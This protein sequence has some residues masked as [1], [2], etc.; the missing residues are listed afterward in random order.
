MIRVSPDTHAVLRELARSEGSSMQEVLSKAV[1]VYRRQQLI[2]ATHAAYAALRA[3]T[4][5]WQE[6]QDEVASLDG[7]LM[8]GLEPEGAPPK[9]AAAPVGR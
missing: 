8:D 4:Q 3:D 7:A 5:A 9:R 1:E 2:E 6:Y